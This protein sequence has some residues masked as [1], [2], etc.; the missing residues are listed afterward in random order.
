MTARGCQTAARLQPLAHDQGGHMES[1]AA[2]R[3]F[4]HAVAL[5]VARRMG[6]SSPTR[7]QEVA[8]GDVRN[9][10][11]VVVTGTRVANRSALET[12]AP[13]DVSQRGDVAPAAF[14]VAQA[15][16][17]PPCPS[18]NFPRPGLADSTDTIRPATLPA[19]LAPDQTLVLVNS[20]RRHA[21]SLVNANN[22]I[23]RDGSRRRRP[24]HHPGAML[25]SVEVLRDGASAQ[26]SSDAIAGVI[27]LR[28]R[29]D[30]E[31]G[32]VTLSYGQRETDHDFRVG[33]PAGARPGA[34][35]WFSQPLRRQHRDDQPLEGPA[36]RCR[37]LSPR[38]RSNTR[39]QDHTERGGW[40]VRPQYP[41]VGGAFDLRGGDLDRF[42]S[43]YG[44]PEPKQS[45]VF[46]TPATRW[47][48]ASR[49][50]AGAAT[51]AARH[52]RRASIASPPT[53]ATCRRSIPTASCRSSRRT[54]TTTARL[55]APWNL[56]GWAVDTSLVYGKNKMQ[57]TIENTLNRSLGA[58]SPRPSTRAVSPTTSWR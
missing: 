57:F 39:D 52:A 41:L 40:D 29:E 33:T 55:S 46:P 50:T 54:S 26:Y 37:G 30:R 6:F 43:W 31:G 42:N 24:Q 17:Q 3:R 18:L 4:R 8:A 14:E 44:E 47:Q 20:K 2:F 10:T 21:A 12:V 16:G 7:A 45:T 5:A 28:L 34:L 22:T 58:A 23:G 15:L 25:R 48:M 51:S 38:W 36:D 27:N 53:P 32:D 56:L 11:E 49:S 19:G 13:V 9:S 1:S 35:P